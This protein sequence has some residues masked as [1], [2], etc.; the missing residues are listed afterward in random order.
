[1][2]SGNCTKADISGFVAKLRFPCINV[3][4]TKYSPA[5]VAGL[6]WT[7]YLGPDFRILCHIL[8]VPMFI[9]VKVL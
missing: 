7:C 3:G 2:R 6:S 4:P 1:M 8:V 9:V 5:L